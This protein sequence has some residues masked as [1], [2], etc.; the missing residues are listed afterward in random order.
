[1]VVC[2]TMSKYIVRISTWSATTLTRMYVDSREGYA[3]FQFAAYHPDL[4]N[5]RFVYRKHGLLWLT[6]PLSYESDIFNA[7]DPGSTG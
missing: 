6:Q 7:D 2:Q 5:A 3:S 1:M 4:F